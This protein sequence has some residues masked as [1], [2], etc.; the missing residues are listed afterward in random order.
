VWQS[1]GDTGSG[2]LVASEDCEI[3]DVHGK[4]IVAL[5][6]FVSDD[7]QFSATGG[8]SAPTWVTG[9]GHGSDSA[10]GPTT[11]HAHDSKPRITDP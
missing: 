9:A 2:S 6:A 7:T 10:L 3:E 5:A 8:S 4:P 11:A 1:L